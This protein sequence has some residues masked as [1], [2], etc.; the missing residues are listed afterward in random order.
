MTAILT[1]RVPAFPAG[2]YGDCRIS[3]CRAIDDR[4]VRSP[5]DRMLPV[6]APF[7]HI[8]ALRERRPDDVSIPPPVIRRLK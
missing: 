6:L 3:A 8:A 7:G 2:I 1:A 5:G 4:A